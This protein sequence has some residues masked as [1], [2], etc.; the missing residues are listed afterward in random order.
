MK[1]FFKDKNFTD[2]QCF[3]LELGV[4]GALFGGQSPAKLPCGNGTGIL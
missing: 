2:L 3:M 1:T 4:F